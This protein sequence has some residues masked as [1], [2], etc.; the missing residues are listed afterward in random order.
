MSAPT[1]QNYHTIS[2]GVSAPIWRGVYIY[3]WHRL[4]AFSSR[5]MFQKVTQPTFNESVC[6]CRPWLGSNSLVGL[7][8]VIAIANC[9]SGLLDKTVKLLRDSSSMALP[10]LQHEWLTPDFFLLS[11]ILGPTDWLTAVRKWPVKFQV[12]LTGY[13]RLESRHCMCSILWLYILCVQLWGLL[14][15]CNGVVVVAA[16]YL[17]L[18]CFWWKWNRDWKC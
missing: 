9:W 18:C 15:C 5:I 11:V 8:V 14:I 10:T 17:V 2:W 3:T 13:Q 12:G 6:I 4:S 1:S 16:F 7:P